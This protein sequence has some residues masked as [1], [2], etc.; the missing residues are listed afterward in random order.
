MLA[1]ISIVLGEAARNYMDQIAFRKAVAFFDIVSMSMLCSF[2]ELSV[3][4]IAILHLF[5][6][7]LN[8]S[9]PR[10][11]S[12]VCECKGEKANTA[13]NDSYYCL[14]NL[15]QLYSYMSYKYGIKLISYLV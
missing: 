13:R 10:C 8:V 11:L 4:P 9:G 14:G 6:S 3:T 15:T 2:K 1:W 7:C 12:G 5:I